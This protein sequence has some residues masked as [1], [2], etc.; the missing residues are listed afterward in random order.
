[1]PAKE[2]S[3]LKLKQL[4]RLHF[5]AKLSNRQIAGSLSLSVGVVNKYINKALS[6]NLSWPLPPELDEQNLK[7]LLIT[8]VSKEIQSAALDK[9]DFA[10]AHQEL[11][12]KSVT[13]QLLWKEYSEQEEKPL[14]Y[15]RYCHYYR[16]YKKV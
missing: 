1:M 15:S 2:I 12:L 10:K 6:I 14:S 3:M 7:K 5:E 8:S 4:L 13:L 9:I 16:V 11:K